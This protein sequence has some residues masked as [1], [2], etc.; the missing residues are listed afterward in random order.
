MMSDKSVISSN[1]S[2]Y[3][4]LIQPIL[5]YRLAY[6]PMMQET[7]FPTSHKLL[8]PKY[9]QPVVDKYIALTY[10]NLEER[11]NQYNGLNTALRDFI[12]PLTFDASARAFFGKECPVGDLLKPFRLFDNNFH[13][14][15]AGIPKFF[16]KGPV[17]ALDELATIVD[18][19]YLSKPDA[20]DD[21]SEMVK[22]YDRITKDD[23]F[24]SRPLHKTSLRFKGLSDRILEKLL[25]CSLAFSGPSRRTPQSQPTGSSHSIFS[26]RK[27]S[28]CS[29]QRLTRLRPTGTR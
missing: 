16:M 27:V 5:T 23:G 6:A 2:I 15:L 20:L 18:E 3:P 4:S 24:V 7:M 19:R 8:S 25:D 28:N 17:K 21:A 12:V 9:V 11:A 10:Q 29:L 13:L 14:L 1:V 26:G 22:A